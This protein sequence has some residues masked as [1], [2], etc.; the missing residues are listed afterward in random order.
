MCNL[1]L[2]FFV[3]LRFFEKSKNNNSK[4]RKEINLTFIKWISFIFD[5]KTFSSDFFL[6]F[7]LTFWYWIYTFPPALFQFE[8]FVLEFRPL[9]SHIKFELKSYEREKQE[10][11]CGNKLNIRLKC[12]GSWKE[13]INKIYELKYIYIFCYIFFKL[14]IYGISVERI[15]Y[16]AFLNGDYLM[17][18]EIERIVFD[19]PCFVIN[20]FIWNFYFFVIFLK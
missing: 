9:G 6:L 19:E 14:R 2:D 20:G 4:V 17:D 16:I 3:F 5:F 7:R 1:I 15:Y 11:S 13:K 18:M 8:F 10:G 12:N